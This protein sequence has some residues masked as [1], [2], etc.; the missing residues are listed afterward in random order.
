MDLAL[1]GLHRGPGIEPE[2]LARRARAAEDAGFESLWVGD[3]VAPPVRAGKD[4]RI[5]AVVAVGFLAAVT[6]R[7]RLAI[8]VVVLPQRH[9][10]LLAKQLSSLDILT[11]GRLTVGVGAGYVEEELA[12]FGV[13][14]TERGARTDDYL[15]TMRAI[16]RGETSH[17]GRFVSYQG[18]AQSPSPVQRPHPPIVVGGHSPAALNRAAR[19][20]NGWFGWDLDLADTGVMLAS[21]RRAVRTEERPARLGVLEITVAPK[22]RLRLDVARRF[23]DLGVHRLV[24][25]ARPGETFEKLIAGAGD[26]L[27]GRV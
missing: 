16:W 11:G 24:L 19:Q 10:V 13:P 23:A 26:A 2:T 25:R 27:V 22:E 15:A 4:D 8:G 20:G 14:L 1:F 3:H 21:L 7:V 17:E 9:P 5:E 6:S 12:A 18:V